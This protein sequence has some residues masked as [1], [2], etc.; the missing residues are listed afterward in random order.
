VPS[1]GRRRFVRLR[2]A[3]LGLLAHILGEDEGKDVRARAVRAAR[4]LEDEDLVAR[5]SRA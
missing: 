3:A 5:V 1:R 4:G 2:I